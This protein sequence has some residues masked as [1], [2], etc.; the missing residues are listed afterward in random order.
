MKIK[1]VKT[2]YHGYYNSNGININITDNKTEITII[3]L[4]IYSIYIKNKK[5]KEVYIN[6]KKVSKFKDLPENIIEI[7]N[8]LNTPF[9]REID[10]RNDF[11]TFECSYKGFHCN[12]HIGYTL[13]NDID[14][15]QADV[16]KSALDIHIL[17][18][19]WNRFD[20]EGYNDEPSYSVN[21][22]NESKW[23]KNNLIEFLNEINKVFD[24]NIII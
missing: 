15:Y 20:L 4:D 22:Y 24:I 19:N 17:R 9:Q 14:Y 10:M 3:G 5:I 6:H 2:H 7:C 1:Q 13:E 12:L 18:A 23:A 16:F 11:N 21:L 8:I